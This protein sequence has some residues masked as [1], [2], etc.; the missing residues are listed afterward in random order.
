VH[1]VGLGP[2]LQAGDLARR[3]T[4]VAGDKM[5]CFSRLGKS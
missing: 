5:L 1:E 4:R 2:Q 3:R